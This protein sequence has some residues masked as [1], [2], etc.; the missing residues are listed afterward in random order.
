MILKKRVLETLHSEI[1]KPPNNIINMIAKVA[2]AKEALFVRKTEARKQNMDSEE[3]CTAKSRMNWRKN[4]N[5]QQM[6]KE[7]QLNR[8]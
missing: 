1:M 4:L 5:P 3:K 2:A 6:I 7:S 8:I